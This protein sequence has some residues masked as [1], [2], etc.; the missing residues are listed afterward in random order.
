M[1]FGSICSCALERTSYRPS[2]SSWLTLAAAA[3]MCGPGCA[4]G[5]PLGACSD[6]MSVVAALT[7][8][9]EAP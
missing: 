1:A 8:S 6:L 7:T 3:R 2:M 4:C 9:L 5:R